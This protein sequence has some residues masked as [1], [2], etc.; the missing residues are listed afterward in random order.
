[1]RNQD[2]GLACC[3]VIIDRGGIGGSWGA[4]R[5]ATAAQH[6]MTLH[7]V[8]RTIRPASFGVGRRSFFSRCQTTARCTVPVACVA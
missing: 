5:D 4:T 6:L 1:M 3:G 7:H 8:T 2:R